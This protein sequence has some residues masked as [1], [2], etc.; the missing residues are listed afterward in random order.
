MGRGGGDLPLPARKMVE[1]VALTFAPPWLVKEPQEATHL[2]VGSV[3]PRPCLQVAWCELLGIRTI[4]F[5]KETSDSQ[6]N[7]HRTE[8][9]GHRV[10]HTA[11]AQAGRACCGKRAPWAPRH[12]LQTTAPW[13]RAS[14]LS[15]P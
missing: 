9:P 5:P 8:K 10:T 3:E 6:R 14:C 13:P 11:D 12:G 1:G 15:Q 4:F 7:T 2:A